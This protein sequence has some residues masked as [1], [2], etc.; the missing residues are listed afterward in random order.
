MTN[1]TSTKPIVKPI[2]KQH[3]KTR[4]K[5]LNKI[6]HINI[7]TLPTKINDKDIMAMFNGIIRL[8]REKINQEQTEKFLKLKL[9]Y[10][11]LKYLYNKHKNN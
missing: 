10:D 2:L 11:Q 9:K 3:T 1:Q 7:C 8:V 4:L 6:E 5:P